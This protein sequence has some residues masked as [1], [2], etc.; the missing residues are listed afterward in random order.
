MK[1]IISYLWDK[2][3]LWRLTSKEKR[4]KKDTRSKGSSK[5]KPSDSLGA[6]KE[7]LHKIKKGLGGKKNENK[8]K[9]S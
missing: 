6:F 3:E 1:K 7:G 5:R 9:K 8:H 2:H 4:A